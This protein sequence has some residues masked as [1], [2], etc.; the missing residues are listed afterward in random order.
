LP[1]EGAQGPTPIGQ[2]AEIKKGFG[3]EGDSL[4]D[5]TATLENRK[6]EDEGKSP[7]RQ[8][9]GARRRKKKTA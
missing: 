6:K 7:A 4:Q 9:R 3:A 5:V 1:R 2:W 8:R